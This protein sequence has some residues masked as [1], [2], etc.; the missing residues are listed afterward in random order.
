MATLRINKG[1][2]YPGLGNFYTGTKFKH[3][4]FSKKRYNSDDVDFNISECAT[5]TVQVHKPQPESQF[6]QYFIY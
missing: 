1:T 6:P 5:L 3:V 2:N 4:R